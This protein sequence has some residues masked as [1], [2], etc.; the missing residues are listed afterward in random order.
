MKKNLKL[1]FENKIFLI[2]INSYIEEK[3]SMNML[4]DNLFSVLK[5]LKQTSFIFTMSNSDLRSDL[6]NYK[7]KTFL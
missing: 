2:T 1:K 3:I 6:I 5:D 4:L 7:I